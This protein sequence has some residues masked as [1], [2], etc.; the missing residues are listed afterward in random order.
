MV[1]LVLVGAGVLTVVQSALNYLIDTFPQYAA[2][3]VAANTFLNNVFAS[4]L[5]LVVGAMY[6]NLG[7]E[8]ATSLVG[9]ISVGML[10]IPFVLWACGER[11]RARGVWSRDSVH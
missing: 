3:A 10:P 9:F 4:V 1:G 7:V 6:K 8:W 11:L 2:S 5:P